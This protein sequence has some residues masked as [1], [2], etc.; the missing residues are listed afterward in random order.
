MGKRK[1]K[2]K[3]GRTK[4]M[5]SP[6]KNRRIIEQFMATDFIDPKKKKHVDYVILMEGYQ[7]LT[8]REVYQ[9]KFN[10]AEWGDASWVKAQW[11]KEVPKLI[12][13]S[14]LRVILGAERAKFFWRNGSTRK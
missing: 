13:R 7:V 5:K 12:H 10:Y 9:I 1:T 3:A 4:P 2:E 8:S 14:K 6:Y 11:P